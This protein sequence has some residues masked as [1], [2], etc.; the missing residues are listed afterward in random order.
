MS[1]ERVPIA[2]SLLVSILVHGAVLSLRFDRPDIEPVRTVAPLRVRLA[3][4]SQT[5][6]ATQNI[7]SPPSMPTAAVRQTE[8]QPPLD[9]TPV[10][11]ER[12]NVA[13][14]DGQRT[15]AVDRA[16]SSD[17][18][19]SEQQA[20]AATESLIE[21]AAINR[22][23]ALESAESSARYRDLLAGWLERHRL[24]PFH[25]RRRGVEGEGL[26]RL[27][28]DRTG[29]VKAFEMARPI[30]DHRLD[31]LVAQMVERADPFPAMPGDLG[32][33][34]FECEIQVRFEL[35]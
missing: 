26:L 27:R 2:V 18:S 1:G 3:P 19:R 20:A 15:V 17:Q 12:R 34:Q 29:R 6:A 32:G 5:A 4:L 22:S 24:Y 10:T 16:S 11:N 23:A 28:V 8:M 9:L 25:L 35:E 30:E 13:K 33:E 21:L 7:P 14:L 31:D